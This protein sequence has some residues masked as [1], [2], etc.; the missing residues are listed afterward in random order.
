MEDCAKQARLKL[1]AELENKVSNIHYQQEELE[2][3]MG[4][5]VLNLLEIVKLH[6]ELGKEAGL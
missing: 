1:R 4:R 2:K 6:Q 5:M 3:R